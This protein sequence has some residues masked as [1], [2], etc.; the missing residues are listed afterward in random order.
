MKA[1]CVENSIILPHVRYI[2]NGERNSLMYH[3]QVVISNGHFYTLGCNRMGVSGLCAG[4]K[5]SRKEF[6]ER[7]CNGIEPETKTNK[8]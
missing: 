7:Y 2:D 3:C 1:Y 6:I 8:E 4:H 5:I